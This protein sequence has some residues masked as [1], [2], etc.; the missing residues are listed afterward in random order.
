[1]STHKSAERLAK[2]LGDID[3]VNSKLRETVGD[4]PTGAWQKMDE[5]HRAIIQMANDMKV[6][7]RLFV[8]GF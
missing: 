1:M 4:T 3:F 5:A 2:I 8:K 7:K 6:L